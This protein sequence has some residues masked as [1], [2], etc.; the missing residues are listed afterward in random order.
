MCFL[1]GIWFDLFHEVSVQTCVISYCT[2]CEQKAK[3]GVGSSERE[4]VD[5]VF[6]VMEE[7]TKE[8]FIT[9]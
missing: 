3:L 4:G 5:C 9:N 6:R 1:F 8:H 7:V 2:G